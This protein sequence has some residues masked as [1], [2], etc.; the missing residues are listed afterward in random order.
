MEP[1]TGLTVLILATNEQRLLKKTLNA[2][3]DVCG[4]DDLAEIIAV[5]PSVD[6]P[7]AVVCEAF[8]PFFRGVPF[9]TYIQKKRDRILF[10][11]EV[12]YRASSSH[13]VIMAA[14]MEMD[15]A[16]LS[17]MLAAAKADPQCI[18]CAAKW[19]RGSDVCGYGRFHTFANVAVNR[20]AALLIRTHDADLFSIFQIYPKE[21]FDR[22][23]FDHTENLLFEYTLKPVV[24]GER[25]MEIPTSYRKR[26]EGAANTDLCLFVRL[27]VCFLVTA[28]RL[29][30][31][32]KLS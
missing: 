16:S 18:V 31:Q 6:C 4:I 22:M 26:E 12:P 20:I 13:F 15:P 24:C 10:F 9:R 2:V 21:V 1:F 3:V 14:D 7:A 5:L 19:L 32:R 23:R 11:S 8:G 17:D 30:F 25:Y 27:A 29:S 28:F